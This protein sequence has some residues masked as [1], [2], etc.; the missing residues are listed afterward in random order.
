MKRIEA[1]TDLID[2][3]A[4]LIP[5][6]QDKGPRRSWWQA[7]TPVPE[8]VNN[9]VHVGLIPGSLNLIVFD[10][11]GC[12]CKSDCK[13]LDDPNCLCYEDLLDKWLPLMYARSLSGK[14]HLYYVDSNRGKCDLFPSMCFKKMRASARK[15][16]QTCGKGFKLA[17]T[18]F[19]CSCSWG[20]FCEH[21]NLSFRYG[22]V[23]GDTRS[24]SG[25]IGMYDDTAMK[26]VETLR[27]VDE[28]PDIKRLSRRP[29]LSETESKSA[30]SVLRQWTVPSTMDEAMDD[31][32]TSTKGS[33]VNSLMA[34]AHRALY[35]FPEYEE[36]MFVSD[37]LKIASEKFLR[38]RDGEKELRDIR[39][40]LANVY[41]MVNRRQQ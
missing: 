37:V 40:Q 34:L 11:D 3:G 29:R 9:D 8:I 21:A 36:K 13:C 1:V 30:V 41:R 35:D 25:F 31:F 12:D 32:R 10:I 33:R 28:N 17:R 6:H 20:L 23:Y 19:E 18:E 27:K 38:Y 24:V 16:A 4:H 22:R 15:C 2:R 39:R 14:L 5:L 7:R 26:L